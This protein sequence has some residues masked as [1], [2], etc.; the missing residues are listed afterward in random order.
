[1]RPFAMW[2]WYS[3]DEVPYAALSRLAFENAAGETRLTPADVRAEPAKWGKS[4][5]TV[6]G[7]GTTTTTN[8]DEDEEE[9]EEETPEITIEILS[10]AWATIAPGQAWSDWVNHGL[11]AALSAAIRI[12]MRGG[13]TREEAIRRIYRDGTKAKE[14][15]DEDVDD[16]KGRIDGETRAA[17]DVVALLSETART[18]LA[19]HIAD[20][21]EAV[22][23]GIAGA[24]ERVSTILGEIVRIF[25]DAG[26]AIPGAP[27][28]GGAIEGDA[29]DVIDTILDVVRGLEL[30]VTLDDDQATSIGNRIATLLGFAL[31]VPGSEKGLGGWLKDTFA[32]LMEWLGGWRTLLRETLRAI[33]G[34]ITDLRG[35]LTR[36]V[37]AQAQRVIG[38]LEDRIA[39]AQAEIIGRIEGSISKVLDKVGLEHTRTRAAVSR[40]QAAVER[41]VRIDGDRTRRAGRASEDRLT[42]HVTTEARRTRAAG[43]ASEARLRGHITSETNRGMQFAAGAWDDLGEG[44]T[45]DVDRLGD[46]LIAHDKTLWERLTEAIRIDLSPVLGWIERLL[47]AERN[48]V[49]R[50]SGELRR[51][52]DE[53]RAALEARTE[54]GADLLPPL[55]RQA[56]S[57]EEMA[58]WVKAQSRPAEAEERRRKSDA[59]IEGLVLGTWD[60]ARPS[61]RRIRAARRR[62][63]DI[64]ATAAGCD[65]TNLRRAVWGKDYTS[66]EDAIEDINSL[67]LDALAGGYQLLNGLFADLVQSLSSGLGGILFNLLALAQIKSECVQLAYRHQV[68]YVPL[69]PADGLRLHRWGAIGDGAV[70]DVLRQHGFN[71][72]RREALIAA[73]HVPVSPGAALD[74][75]HRELVTEGYLDDL[76]RRAGLDA[77]DTEVAKKQSFY[78]APPSDLI[79][80]AV[81]D[82]FDPAARRR[83]SLDEDFPPEFER[84]AKRIGITESL[85]RDYWAAHWSLPAVGQG[86]SMLHR[87]VIDDATL[88]DL[89][90]AKDI[91]PVWRPRLK[92]ISYR[93]LNRVDVRR[94]YVTGTLDAAQVL[95][96]YKDLGYDDRNAAL[97]RDFTVRW[98]EDRAPTEDELAARGLT[99]SLVLRLYARGTV[100]REQAEALLVEAGMGE[101]VAALWIASAEIEEAA[102]VEGERVD[103]VLVRY[104]EGI[105]TER[106]AEQDLAALNLTRAERRVIAERMDQIRLS[107]RRLPSRTDCDRMLKAGLI[108][109]E[110]YLE[111]MNRIGYGVKWGARFYELASG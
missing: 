3:W 84:A 86:Y 31:R 103:T 107:R 9:A 54:T 10:R 85:A 68:Q 28:T 8:T 106:E 26:V 66:E 49:A 23:G 91:A 41:V 27:R 69:S 111:T 48:E 21:C 50:V 30:G 29:A 22:H 72:G 36:I 56:T 18:R 87:G 45:H 38:E 80:M 55:E 5:A 52:L 74:A 12:L 16:A 19:E 88:D 65:T 100:D 60:R 57:L 102:R 34:A 20:V 98:A 59:V 110:E 37:I 11:A 67:I 77:T 83:L 101:D 1:M 76:L 42:G 73:N 62:L 25:V 47:A 32:G 92:A 35:T 15:V 33:L 93:T 94:M 64:N 24:T 4:Y 46:R 53:E 82:V 40:A 75:W 7:P 51:V 96:A 6:G 89:L 70:R 78:R 97:M 81:R 58:D 43:A 2:Q 39:E 99:R 13:L 71:E 61:Q 95:K 14:K 63:W 108:E 90:R 79:L 17:I 104:R 105:A 109:K 44:I